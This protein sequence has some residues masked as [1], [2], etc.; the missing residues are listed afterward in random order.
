MAADEANLPVKA[1][2]V[3]TAAEPTFTFSEFFERVPPS[4]AVT[5]SDVVVR[6]L[7]HL[8]GGRTNTVVYMH[9]P[10]IELH[11]GN[12]K[13]GGQRTFRWESGA[14]GDIPKPQEPIF[15]R[16][17][18][19]NCQKT[20]KTFSFWVGTI[21]P[22]HKSARCYKFGEYPSFGSPTPPRLLKLLGKDRDI[23]LQGRQCEN[24]GLGIGAFAYYRRVVENQRNAIIDE[25]VRV[26]E[27]LKAPDDLVQALLAAKNENQFA[28][29]VAAI[30]DGIPQVLFI[31]GHNPLTLLH[32]ALSK[33][34]HA[35]ADQTC[36]EAAHI[37]RIVLADLV[38]RVGQ[39]LKSEAELTTALGRLMGNPGSP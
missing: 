17:L 16:Y 18:C 25:I 6:R 15:H 21:G 37:I 38:E 2:A 12:A 30:K 35:E 26:S 22:D 8:A 10:E 31:D 33:G 7:D 27:K 23:Y 3:P 32:S 5:V 14:A 1:E 34:L 13:C 20:T 4:K 28:K 9:R 11:C 39:A 29:S 36:L 19:S 24:Q